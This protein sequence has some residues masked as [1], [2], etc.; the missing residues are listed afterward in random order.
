MILSSARVVDLGRENE[1]SFHADIGSHN[2]G[3]P[4]LESARPL[5]GQGSAV[6]RRARILLAANQISI[7]DRTR[8]VCHAF[9]YL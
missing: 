9:M 7:V 6:S 2:T 1:S 4:L 8:Q 3:P 5:F